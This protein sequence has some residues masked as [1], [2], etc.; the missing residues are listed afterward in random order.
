[1][2]LQEPLV[3]IIIP[4]FNQQTFL[5]EALNSVKD[6]IYQNWECILVDDGSTDN[7][8]LIAQQYVS[9]DRR[10]MYFYKINEGVSV[11]RNFGIKQSKGEYILPL[12]GDDKISP[13]YIVEIMNMFKKCPEAKMVSSKACFFGEKSGY[14]DLKEYTFRD[15]L[16]GNMLHCSGVF[17]RK[18]YDQT[19][20]YRTNMKYG[21]EDWDFWISLL[22]PKDIVIVLPEPLFY[23]RINV[24]SRTSSLLEDR[25]RKYRRMKRQ[26]FANNI[27]KY[28]ITF[29]VLPISFAYFLNKQI[30]QV[31]KAIKSILNH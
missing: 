21:L 17:R 26:V 6:Q 24:T 19:L 13:N 30:Y 18:D 10:F 28:Y 12:D 11:A 8:Q 23:Y 14:W 2:S 16:F 4:C 29:E 15:L 9:A 22:D 20:G 3:S 7:S 5:S 31:H 1:M 25:K 27:N